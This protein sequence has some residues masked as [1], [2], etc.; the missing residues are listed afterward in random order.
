M[1][2]TR[3]DAASAVVL[4]VTGALDI[5]S[6]PTFR[7][8]LLDTLATAPKNVVVDLS[9]LDFLASAGLAALVEGHRAAGA[10]TG[11]GVVAVG[12]ATR[13]PLDLTGLTEVIAVFDTL[14]E[15]VSKLAE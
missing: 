15:A 6:A 8:A 4:T 7:Q 10:A 9:D 2:V 14:D 5:L 12:S 1:N 3:S 11:F 13:R